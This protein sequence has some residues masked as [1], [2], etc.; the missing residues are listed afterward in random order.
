LFHHSSFVIRYFPVNLSPG[1]K[2]AGVLVPL[3]ALRAE[4]DLGVGDLGAL[5]EFIDWAAEIGF[6]LVQLLPINE[7]GTDNSP[8]NAISAMAIEPTTLHLA[9]NSPEDLTR[10]DFD[11]VIS[12]ADPSTALRTSL[13]KLRHGEVKY[14]QVKKLKRRLLEKAFANFS[15]RASEERRLKFRKFCEEEAAWL[16]DYAFFRVVMEQNEE[17]AAWTRWPAE[18][19][20]I[21][22]VRAWLRD[23]PQ[24]RQAAIKERQNFFRYVQWT[25]HQQWRE[26]KSYAE[27]R[28]VALMGDIPFGVSYYSADVFARPDEFALDWS[29][30]APPELYF[31]DDEFTQKW[32]QNWGIPLYR[33]D[34]MGANNFEWWRERV[35]A[36]R[37]IFHLFRIDHVLGFYRVYAFP[38]RPRKNKQFLPLDRNEMLEQTGGRA[39][40]FAPRDDETS[41]NREANKREGEE[42]LRVILDE[43]G[44]TRVIGEDLGM[45]PDY[46]RPSLRSLGIAGFKIPQWEVRHEKVTSGDKYER[47]SVAT[48]ATHDHKPI[49]AFWEEAFERLTPTSEQSRYDL[50]KIAAFAGLN[51]KIDRIDFEKDFY[52]VIMEALFKSEAWI[53]IVMITD[54]LARKYRFNVPGT[55]A[56][57]NWTRRMQRSVA[58]LRASPRE[59]AR[60]HLIRLLLQ[61]TGRA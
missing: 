33:W 32:G 17:S 3:F 44:A 25:A 50:A 57:L 56:N 48:Y 26:I 39:P 58:Q 21:K 31:K 47:L 16:D 38:W 61:K 46:V 30:G 6:R 5:R 27:E 18:H 43:A 29:G 52:P 23:L 7:T 24:D 13:V 36:V 8:Y 4:S 19:Q 40:H 15:Q 12:D 20:S 54:L 49:R 9:A 10:E 59:R 60:M 14:R 41:E 22:K 51:P 11:A 1:K 37:S 2:I 53:A 35:R 55:A 42:Y 28:E 45:V 34:R